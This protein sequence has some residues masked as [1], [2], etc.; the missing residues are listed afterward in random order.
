MEFEQQQEMV[1]TMLHYF[2]TKQNY[3]IVMLHGAKDEIWLE[4]LDYDYKIIRIVSNYIHNE[5]QLNYDLLRVKQISKVVKKKTVSLNIPVLT[6]FVNLGDNVK[7]TDKENI[8]CFHLTSIEDVC[9]NNFITNIFKDIENNLKHQENG[10]QLFVKLSNEINFKT[11]KDSVKTEKVFAP[12]LPIITYSLIAINAIL[13]LL[14]FIIGNGS[15]D[16]TTLVNFG[17]SNQLLVLEF[18]QYYRI[19]TAAFLHFDILHLALNMYALYFVGKQIESFFGKY[20]FLFIYFASAII[21]SMVSLLFLDVNTLSVGASGAVFGLFGSLIYFG[22]NYRLYLGTILKSQLI[23]ILILNLTL[24]FMIGGIDNAAHI[25]GL[26]GGVL[27][28]MA[29]G[30]SDKS[31]TKD[32]INGIILLSI[33]TIF[34]IFMLMNVKF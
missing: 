8:K 27:A 15:E 13:F 5:E 9:K 14:M 16:I 21:G 19:I 26:I 28:T 20:K 33:F 6:F 31:K 7:L 22:Y 3:N 34:I 32:K 25:G 17:A 4:N 29:V 11:K 10:Q 12:K 2:I 24:G 23:P 30:V 18:N 1:M